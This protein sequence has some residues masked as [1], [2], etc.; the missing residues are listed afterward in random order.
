MTSTA[1]V[2]EMSSKAFKIE[3]SYESNGTI[4]SLGEDEEES[5]EE[6]K[7]ELQQT[8]NQQYKQSYKLT[9]AKVKLGKRLKDALEE[10]ESLKKVNEDAQAEISQLK[11]HRTL[12]DKVRFLEKDAFDREGFK[13][14]L[15][16]KILKLEAYLLKSSLTFKKYEACESTIEKVCLKS[17]TCLGYS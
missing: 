9:D 17:E 2:K 5:D 15:E 12:T 16:E 10:V 6:H 14:A 1:E 11:N 13:K 8:Y 7:S 4:G 3:K